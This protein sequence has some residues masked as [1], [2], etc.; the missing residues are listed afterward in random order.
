MAG[1]AVP[2]GLVCTNLVPSP[3]S[4][5]HPGPSDRLVLSLLLLAQVRLVSL[6]QVLKMLT[7]EKAVVVEVL[8]KLLV[9][10]LLLLVAEPV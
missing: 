8:L 10:T 4:C 3:G 1:L 6:L 7:Q 5:R 9:V 2:R